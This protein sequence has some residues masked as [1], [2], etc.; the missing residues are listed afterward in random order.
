MHNDLQIWRDLKS[1]ILKLLVYCIL[2]RLVGFTVTLKTT[3]LT[4][5]LVRPTETPWQYLIHP[6]MHAERVGCFWI[7]V[8]MWSS[9][10]CSASSITAVTLLCAGDS[11]LRR[12]LRSLRKSVRAQLSWGSTPGKLGRRWATASPRAERTAPAGRSPCWRLVSAVMRVR[13]HPPRP[14]ATP[15]P[16]KSSPR[17]TF[18]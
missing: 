8:P 1:R 16:S 11:S 14:R 4:Y 9:R 18:T 6:H 7:A 2:A 15:S 12:T 3:L 10:G 13:P 17:Q 5:L